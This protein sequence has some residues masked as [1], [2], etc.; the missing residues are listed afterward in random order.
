MV[1]ANDDEL[2]MSRTG[3]LNR[4]PRRSPRG[5]GPYWARNLPHHRRARPCPI[6]P[7]HRNPFDPSR[8]PTRL[9]ERRPAHRH[10]VVKRTKIDMTEPEIE[11]QPS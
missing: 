5:G 8:T 6:R 1:K 11:T 3:R 7:A 10:H 9:D 4:E 2:A